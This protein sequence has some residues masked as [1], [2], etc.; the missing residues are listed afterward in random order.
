MSQ[1]SGSVELIELSE[2]DLKG[3]KVAVG[4]RSLPALILPN[5]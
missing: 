3:F 5:S 2:D 1:L 4:S